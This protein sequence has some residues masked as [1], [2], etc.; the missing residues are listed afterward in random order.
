MTRQTV[1]KVAFPVVVLLAVSFHSQNASAQSVQLPTIG[2]FNVRTVV[3]VPD[4]G[5]MQIG[6][7]Q[8]SGSQRLGRGIPG[9]RNVPG[10]GR[11]LGN[12]GIGRS[13]GSS[14]A[15]VHPRLII[16]SELEAEVMA[17]AERLQR[18]AAARDPNGSAEVQKKADF[19]SRNIGRS[20]QRR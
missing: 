5:S 7:V 18:E 16:M 20:G 15:T 10:A 9:L 4:G 3:S 11:L 14:R 2:F 13:T 19:I 8:R 1:Y 6:G 17:G 12:R